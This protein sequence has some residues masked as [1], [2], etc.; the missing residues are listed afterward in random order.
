MRRVLTG[1]AT[2]VA[3]IAVPV[4]ATAALLST[5]LLN[6]DDDYLQGGDLPTAERAAQVADTGEGKAM[7]PVANLQYDRSGEAQAGSDIEF[8]RVG[9]RDFALAGTLRKGMQIIN[10]SNPREP[11]RVAVYDCDISQGDVQVWDKG[12]RILASYTADGTFGTA[13][14]A[15][16]CA[17]DLN[18]GSGAAGTV[19]VD[20]TQPADPSTVGFAPVGRGSHN[21]SV[22]PSGNYLYNSNSDLITSTEPS[23]DVFDIRRPAHPRQVAD[24]RIPYVPTT[25]G[26]ES[27]DIAFS[28]SGDRAYSAALSQQVVLDTS[29]PAD[30]E[31]ITSFTDPAINLSHQA[32]PITM[33]TEDGTSRRLLVVTDERAG[34]IGSAEC[35]G[36]GL[37]VYD[38]TGNNVQDPLENKLGTWFIPTVQPQAGA[39]CTSH[40][41]R[42]YPDQ[43]MMTIAWYSQGARVLDISGLADAPVNPAAVAIG[44][45]IGMKE[46]GHYVFPDSDAWSFKTNRINRDGSFFGYANDLTRGFDVIRFRGAGERVPPLVPR[47]PRG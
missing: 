16:Q 40:V 41:L 27:H 14:A 1:A 25:L 37:H 3:V 38:I 7:R 15:S 39:T 42:M 29:D 22:H 18:L 8:V 46:I 19:I 13:G 9:S 33:R 12:E 30:P 10:I 2:A 32:D 28:A 11:R 6:P 24:L 26:S 5:P 43:E 47:D 17:K 21:M 20:I 44:D 4:G 31:I 45:G 36:G 23:I 35:P 34:A